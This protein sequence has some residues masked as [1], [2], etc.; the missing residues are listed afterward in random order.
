MGLIGVDLF[1]TLIIAAV[2]CALPASIEVY[3]IDALGDALGAGMN[4]VFHDRP[5]IH[6]NYFAETIEGILEYVSKGFKSDG[7][8]WFFPAL[9]TSIWL[10]LY[11]ACGFLLKAARRFDF[12]FQWFNRH[13]DIEKKPLQSIGLVAGA[14]VAVVYWAAVVVMRVV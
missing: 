14:I 2:A 12:G 10:W 7:A 3:A 5:P 1:I 13:F 6:H 8:I 4:A 9:W 11:A